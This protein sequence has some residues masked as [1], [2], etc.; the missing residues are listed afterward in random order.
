MK[1]GARCAVGARAEVY[2]F[3]RRFFFNPHAII[4]PLVYNNVYV[5]LTAEGRHD[6]QSLPQWRLFGLGAWANGRGVHTLKRSKVTRGYRRWGDTNVRHVPSGT[7][8][9][10]TARYLCERA[11]KPAP[12]AAALLVK[13][14]GVRRVSPPV[15][16]GGYSYF[17]LATTICWVLLSLDTQPFM[18]YSPRWEIIAPW[19]ISAKKQKRASRLDLVF[20]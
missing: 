7:R 17:D 8:E 6:I 9:A 20:G 14:Y 15:H 16:T 18:P 13:E 4:Y 10:G 5:L 19:K 2:T 1:L 3:P 11:W 12:G